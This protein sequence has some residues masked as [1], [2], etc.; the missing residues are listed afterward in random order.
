M[1]YVVSSQ[2]LGGDSDR[3]FVFNIAYQWTYGDFSAFYDNG[4]LFYYPHQLG[5]II[6]LYYFSLIFGGHNYIALEICNVFCVILTYKAFA[7]LSDM[8]GNSRIKTFLILTTCILFLPMSLYTTFAYGTLL[9]LCLAVNAV[10]HIYICRN[11][12]SS[13]QKCFHVVM[14]LG[15]LFFAAVIK[16]N[17]LIFAIGYI[18][19]CCIF[20]SENTHHLTL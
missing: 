11:T 9:G 7:D 4:Y 5:L 10:R 20:F 6:F 14:S 19:L 12:S 16:R 18:I 15:E 2:R 8:S 3:T 13:L 17:Y 1:V